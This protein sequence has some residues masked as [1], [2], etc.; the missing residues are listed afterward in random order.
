MKKQK[1]TKLRIDAYRKVGTSAALQIPIYFDKLPSEIGGCLVRDSHIVISEEEDYQTQLFVYC[2]ELLHYIFNHIRRGAGKDRVLWGLAIDHV[3]NN[4]LT[5]VLE[6]ESV[7]W[8]EQHRFILF[9]DIPDGPA[10]LIYRE[11]QRLVDKTKKEGKTEF[12]FGGKTIRLVP[13]TVDGIRPPKHFTEPLPISTGSL[14]EFENHLKSQGSISAGVLR[15]IDQGYKSQVPWERVLAARILSFIGK[16]VA[17]P[18]YTKLPYYQIACD[19]RL[20]GNYKKEFNL[21]TAFDTSGSISQQE[22]SKFCAEYQRVEKLVSEH[23][24]YVIDADIHAVLHNPSYDELVANLRGGGGTSL[25]PPFEDVEKRKLKPD[26][27]V[28][29][30]DTF[31]TFPQKTP[32]YSVIWIV[33][34]TFQTLDIRV[35]FGTV[36]YID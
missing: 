25:A 34:R 21:V 27:F 18:T 13:L 15:E 26:L 29:F 6:L 19:V 3:V 30:T 32:T 35:P 2:H 1:D 7:N 5:T 22:L 14:Y 11:L 16:K 23:W 36:Y 24:V 20:A 8:V 4:L 9:R 10:E 31:G 28:Y 17:T 12:K 33:V